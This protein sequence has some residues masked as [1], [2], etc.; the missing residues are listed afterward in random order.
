MAESTSTGAWKPT[1]SSTASVILPLWIAAS[2]LNVSE[3]TCIKPL[4][5]IRSLVHTSVVTFHVALS[6][7]MLAPAVDDKRPASTSMCSATVSVSFKVTP[8]CAWTLTALADR[9]RFS[10]TEFEINVNAVSPSCPPASAVL[11]IVVV[12]PESVTWNISRV[13]SKTTAWSLNAN[14]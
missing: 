1:E 2:D 7:S 13:S 6:A 8:F 12:V 5:V 3:S 9:S 4:T 11:P 14:V 10:S